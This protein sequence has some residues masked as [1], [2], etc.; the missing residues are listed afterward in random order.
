MPEVA[1]GYDETNLEEFR[2]DGRG[3]DDAGYSCEGSRGFVES[4]L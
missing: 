2:G 1:S 3:A 4:F